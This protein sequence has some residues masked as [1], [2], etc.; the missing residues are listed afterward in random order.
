L[1][2]SRNYETFEYKVDILLNRIL[3]PP[4]NTNSKIASTTLSDPYY[5]SICIPK[6]ISCI[7]LHVS[8]NRHYFPYLVG[9]ARFCGIARFGGMGPKNFTLGLIGLLEGATWNLLI[10]P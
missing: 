1:N 3:G 4:L 9:F 8:L 5:A 6:L 7:D 10:S 2:S